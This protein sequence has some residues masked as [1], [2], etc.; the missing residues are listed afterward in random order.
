M[1]WL[2]CM[3]M[4]LALASC[5]VTRKVEVE[6]GNPALAKLVEGIEGKTMVQV[7]SL[8]GSP[9]SRWALGNEI[10][11][12]YHNHVDDKT[13]STFFAELHFDAAGRVERVLSRTA[14]PAA[15]K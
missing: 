10:W 5:G 4:V 11:L 7:R 2:L 9:Q 14:P 6:Q 13:S 15:V 12:Y 1:R 3:A 8:L